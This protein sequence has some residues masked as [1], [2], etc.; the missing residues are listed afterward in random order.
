MSNRDAVL[1]R[2]YRDVKRVLPCSLAMK[3]QIVRQLQESVRGYLE[4]NPDANMDAVQQHFGT[5]QEIA[6]GY[7]D[8]QDASELLKKMTI[9]KR[10]LAIIAG[11]MAAVLLTWAGVVAWAIAKQKTVQNGYYVLIIDEE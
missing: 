8:D 10:V 2:Y 1:K 5:P 4:Q 9:K 6:S 11:T 3:K 7:I